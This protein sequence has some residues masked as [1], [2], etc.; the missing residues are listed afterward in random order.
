MRALPAYNR[1]RLNFHSIR[2]EPSMP[3][4]N[5]RGFVLASLALLMLSACATTPL[6]GP[7]RSGPPIPAP[8]LA[9]GDRWVYHVADGFRVRQ[10]WDETHEIVAMD[11][12]GIT[13]N[14]TLKGPG[15]DVV[16]T[17]KWSAPGV[18]LVGAVH[19]AETRRFEPPLVRYQYPLTPGETWQQR[20]RDP[21]AP[22]GPFGPIQRQVTVQG[23]ESVTTPAG[24]FDALRMRVALTLDD[25]TF[26]RFPTRC[27][28]TLW[29]AERSG[30][31]VQERKRCWS[32]DKSSRDSVAE[33]P[34]Q[35]ADVQLVSFSR[36]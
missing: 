23:Y 12:S 21:Q 17:E 25:E 15:V 22:P 5:R 13:V 16:R 30:A 14:V 29:Y 35:N 4:G 11:A 19:E 7:A 32:R 10:E 9:V 8:K 31:T 26:Y 27:D 2:P 28:Y 24:T 36:R 34:G 18:V 3:K 1:T 33:H 6:E 20:I